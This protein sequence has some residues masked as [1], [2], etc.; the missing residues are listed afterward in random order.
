MKIA[1]V[2]DSMDV[3][4][5]ETLVSQMCRLQREQGHNPSVYAVSTLGDLG[6]QMQ[7]EGFVVQP[8]MG[9]NL[10]DASLNFYRVFKQLRPDVVHL[11]NPT[12]TIFAAAAARLAGVPSIV[13]TRHSL[14][15]APRKLTVELKYALAARFCDWIVGICEA[16]TNNL[17]SAHSA[18]SRKIVCVYN[19]AAALTR[20]AKGEWPPKSGFT[21]LYVGRLEPVKNHRLLL[22]AFRGALSSM[23]GLHLWMVGD[24]NERGA[25]ET[26]AKD[27][28]IAAQVTFWGQQ[29]D[30][31]PYFSAADAFIMS[32]RSEGLPMSLLQAF[33]LGL[34]AIV[35]DVGGMAE[36]VRLAQAGLTV[37]L[38]GPAEMTAAI[39]LLASKDAERQQFSRNTRAAFQ[40][41]FTLQIMVDAYMDLYRDTARARHM[42]HT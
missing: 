13:S 23:P 20:V 18:P 21:L 36:V 3:G 15:A 22:N 40:A 28:G 41:S 26:L 17:K 2:V 1:H 9:R 30:V 34:P 7:T 27:L 8:H 39:Q 35:T 19:G 12:P 33:S 25:L 5:A 38:T 29:L 4:G 32:S 6:K 42:A 10:P 31:A 16:T 14:V 37:S 11:H 24:G